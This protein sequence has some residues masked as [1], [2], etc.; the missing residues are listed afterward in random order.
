[1]FKGSVGH[2]YPQL[3]TY[4]TIYNFIMNLGEGNWPLED[5]YIPPNPASIS[6]AITNGTTMII[7]IGSYKLLLSLSIGAAS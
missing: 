1:M 5:S 2:S 7:S 3:P 6:Q 4:D